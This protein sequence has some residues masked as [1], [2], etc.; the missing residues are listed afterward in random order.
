M[1]STK[2]LRV[3]EISDQERLVIYT[4]DKTT[5]VA[6]VRERRL[7]DTDPWEPETL[8]KFPRVLLSNFEEILSPTGP[9]LLQYTRVEKARH[10]NK[11][12][13]VNIPI[14][15][16]HNNKD[17]GVSVRRQLCWFDYGLKPISG[18]PISNTML[19]SG[20][21]R[22]W[23]CDIIAEQGHTPNTSRDYSSGIENAADNTG[24]SD[25]NIRDDRDIIYIS[26]DDEPQNI[27]SAPKKEA[28][29]QWLQ[30]SKRKGVKRVL[31]FEIETSTPRK[32]PQTV[33]GMLNFLDL[34]PIP[35][36]KKD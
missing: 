33:E 7:I 5:D 14:R 9:S 15:R 13:S 25:T 36:Y 1:D 2:S 4:S 35:F 17:V 20:L 23:E 22:F 11:L 19:V 12:H 27:Q 8:Q 3:V 18:D 34:S 16:L 29:G 10:T 28:R 26:S 31:N 21:E 24:H 6:L 30:K 32:L